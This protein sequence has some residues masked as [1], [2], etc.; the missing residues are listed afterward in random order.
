[1]DAAQNGAK[2]FLS[3]G[4]ERQS[5]ELMRKCH[6]WARLL[7]LLHR[8]NGVTWKPKL[9]TESIDFPGGGRIM[10]LPH[11]PLAI[12]GFTGNITFD[13]FA[14]HPK[15]VEMWGSL[16][17][18]IS[19]GYRVDVM[20]RA[21][22]PNNRFAEIWHKGSENWSRHRCDG[23][24][25][26]AY[27][28]PLDLELLRQELGDIDFRQHCMCEFLDEVFTLLSWETITNAVD[29]RCS[30]CSTWNMA[31]GPFYAG[32]DIG[33][34]T[35]WT[36]LWI[37]QQQGKQLVTKAV[38]PIPAKGEARLT[39]PEQRRRILAICNHP[40]LVKI[41]VDA[42]GI[43]TDMAESLAEAM[44]QSRVELFTFTGGI[45]GGAKGELFIAAKD[46]L[47]A[48]RLLIPESDV[49]RDD[50]Y[51][52]ERRVTTNGNITYTATRNAGGHADHFCAAALAVR[53]ADQ[54]GP[55]PAEAVFGSDLRY[56]D[57]RGLLC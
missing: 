55:G 43:G 46:A 8:A 22:G 47:E 49:I 51:S 57:R 20:S 39:L 38:I 1:M 21:N 37:V 13:E 54:G 27:G 41:A 25:A 15:A 3:S 17:P 56:S 7:E 10:S 4:G 16:L 40:T 11:N 5:E 53:A 28:V 35:D 32:L 30:E 14:Q 42:T 12:E 6:G 18:S 48:G 52:V 19:Q 50:F 44:G 24:Q 29:Q 2:W 26:V 9:R 36:V 23:P 31:P 33:R 34:T 45:T